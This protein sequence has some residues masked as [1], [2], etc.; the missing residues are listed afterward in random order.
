[1]FSNERYIG[2]ILFEKKAGLELE[3]A[4]IK[5]KDGTPWSTISTPTHLESHSFSVPYAGQFK[6]E[7]RYRLEAAAS[8]RY[9]STVVDIAQDHEVDIT[10]LDFSTFMYT[11]AFGGQRVQRQL[12][13]DEGVAFVDDETIDMARHRWPPCDEPGGPEQLALPL[14]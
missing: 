1:M 3:R 6:S 10:W 14:G 12:L 5:R 4:L 11:Y 8:L 9:A 13:E 7:G 2:A